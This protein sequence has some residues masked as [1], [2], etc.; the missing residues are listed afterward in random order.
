MHGPI[1]VGADGSDTSRLAIEEAASIARGSR[2]MVVVVFVRHAPFGAIGF[3]GGGG[4]SSV[5]V[6]DALDAGE[7]LAEAQSIAILD[8]AQVKWR[9]EVRTGEPAAE[10]MSLATELG[11]EMIVV[12]GRRHSALGGFTCASVSM[13]LLHRWPHSL[14]IIHPPSDATTRS[15]A[16]TTAS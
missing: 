13:R 6:Q 16:G 12:A 11:S 1:V 8:P 3:V 9:F 14:L 15:T 5:M 4:L 7:A 2:Q 10:L